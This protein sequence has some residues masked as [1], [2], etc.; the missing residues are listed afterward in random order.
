MAQAEEQSLH[1]AAPLT[2]VQVIAVNGHQKALFYSL[3][4]VHYA[5]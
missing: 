2:H 3:M 4:A 5:V 1:P